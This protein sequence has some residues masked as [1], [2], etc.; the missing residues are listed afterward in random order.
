[1]SDHQQKQIEVIDQIEKQISGNN[2][3]FTTVAPVEDFKNDRRI[4]LT[5]VHLPSQFLKTKVEQ[6]IIKPLLAIAPSSYGYDTSSLHMTI[7]NIRV[8]ND[9]PHFNEED[10]IKA[11]KVFSNIIPKH[12]KFK[13]Y[14]YRLLLFPNNLAL[15]GTTDPELDN[16]VADLDRNLQQ[17]NI[18]DDKKYVNTKYFFSNMT[19]MRFSG[20]VSGE[21]KSK[22]K[23]LSKKINLDPYVVDTVSLITANAVLSKLKIIE[24]W[25]LQ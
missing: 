11:K 13:V 5:S 16:I 17:N 4:C 8:I 15:I 7:K 12:H 18:R 14:F 3:Q 19:L 10:V 1:M 2:L 20:Q 23:E 21:F 6:E 25:K 22:V 24:T 9:P